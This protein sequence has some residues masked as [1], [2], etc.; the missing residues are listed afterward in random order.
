MQALDSIAVHRL[1]VPLTVPYKL[2]FGPVEH[3]DTIIAETV[4]RDGRAGFGEAT[5][6]TGYTDETID[7][8]WRAAQDLAAG[9]TAAGDRAQQRIA[10][11]GVKFPF[12]ATAFGTALE[13]LSGSPLLDLAADTA[14]PLVGLLNAKDEAA[15]EVEVPKLLES[16]YRTIKVKVGFEVA[17]D[18]ALV[19]AAQKIVRGR[20]ALRLDANQ[21]YTADE[22]VRF[23]KALDPEGIELFEQ[24]CAAGDWDAH[25]AVVRA[26]GVPMMLDESIYGLADIERAARLEAA[27]YLKLKLMK[28]VTLSALSKAI[29]RIRELGMKPVLGNGVACDP[30]CWMEGCIAAR[31]ID[32]AGEMNGFLKA[33][34]P[35]IENGLAFRNGAMQLK[36]GF[37]L[38][39]DRAA[40]RAYAIDSRSFG[41]AKRT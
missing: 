4:D 11:L 9:L 13:M 41:G 3:F 7:D 17:E 35:L 33:R 24:P 10:E 30:G 23:V 25:R 31:Q 37:A 21:A 29:D 36:R 16:G 6:L 15:M 18:I 1:R 32:N 22:G 12:T 40:L 20:A 34:S 19:A 39:L 8:S 26:A 28:L 5:I 2:A 38:R 14:V 27:T